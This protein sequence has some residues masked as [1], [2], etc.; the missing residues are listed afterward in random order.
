MTTP[1]ALPALRLDKW[2]WA[3]RLF[4]TRSLAAEQADLG[5]VCVNGVV[6]KPSRELRPSDRLT[7]R[8]GPVLREFDVLALSKMRGPAAVA[9]LLYR[10]TPQSVASREAAAEARR[11]SPEPAESLEQGRPTKRDR[12][13]LADWERWSARLEDSP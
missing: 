4:K 8:Q 11:V 9:Q 3:A 6:A 12:R 10:E 13:Q 2:L 7:L 5:R 1:P